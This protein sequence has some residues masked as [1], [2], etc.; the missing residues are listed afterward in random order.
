MKKTLKM[1]LF[2][3]LKTLIISFDLLKY[4]QSKQNTGYD[5]SQTTYK[6][7]VEFF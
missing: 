2:T 7:L 3:R 1:T 5:N 4:K 6:V